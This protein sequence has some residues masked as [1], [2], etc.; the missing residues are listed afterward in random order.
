MRLDNQAQA[1]AADEDIVLYE[2][3]GVAVW[4]SYSKHGHAGTYAW[5]DFR[6]GNVIVKNADQEIINKMIDIA[7]RLKAKVQGD[8]GE[9]YHTKLLFADKPPWWKFWR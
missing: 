3:S 7:S 4:T 6:N 1:A 2:N 8:D 9:T 5:F